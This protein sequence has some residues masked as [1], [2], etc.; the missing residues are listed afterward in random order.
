[1]SA[2]YYPGQQVIARDGARYTLTHYAELTWWGVRGSG[3]VGLPQ[4]VV[5]RYPSWGGD[6]DRAG[7]DLARRS[8]VRGQGA[9]RGHGARRG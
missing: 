5:V 6:D 2:N 9:V 3:A 4:P 1:M 8:V 7:A